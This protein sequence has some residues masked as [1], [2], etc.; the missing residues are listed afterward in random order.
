MGKLDALVEINKLQS[1]TLSRLIQSQEW[2]GKER[3]RRFEQTTIINCRIKD[4]TISINEFIDYSKIVQSEELAVNSYLENC[5]EYVR[6]NIKFIDEIA[7]A[8][9]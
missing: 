6:N 8:M 1:E 5:A 4:Q 9:R 2:I 3:T 7:K